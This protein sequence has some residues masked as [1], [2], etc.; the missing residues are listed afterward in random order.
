VT[1]L[2]VVIPV[3]NELELV[4]ACLRSVLESLEELRLEAEVIV[5]DDASTDGA[6]ELVEQEF[7]GVRSIAH[8]NNR[9]FAVSANRGLRE[10]RGELLLLLNSDTEVDA[11]GLLT[12]LNELR[13][14][15][16]CSA[17]APRLVDDQGATQHSLMALPRLS[18]ALY[19]GTPLER[20]LPDSAEL[21]RY[22][23]R[24]LDHELSSEVAQPPAAAWMLRRAAWERVGEF[25]EQLEL[26]FNDV[27]WC[28]R[29][30]EQGGRFRYLAEAT[31]VHHGGA[32]TRH[33]ADF[34]PRWQADRLRYYR[35]HFG[36]TGVAWVKL[37]VSLTFADWC[38]RNSW[39]RMLGRASEPLGPTSRAFAAF[40]RGSALREFTSS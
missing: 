19:F 39:R 8:E 34:V 33:R 17:V 29:F 21:E 1:E 2:S 31:V 28:L 14:H 12:M 6:R 20:L 11:R 7:P 13:D 37:C 9:G 35:K 16:E 4:R 38:V 26:F 15:P 24:D 5:V 18:T 10:A 40:L 36:R 32:S 30:G 25:D 22:F 23:A 27:D 3:F